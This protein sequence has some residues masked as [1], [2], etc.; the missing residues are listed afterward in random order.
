[1]QRDLK[2]GVNQ[3]TLY[4]PEFLD[5]DGDGFRPYDG[6]C[7]DA[8]PT[9][10]PD[11]EEECDGIDNDCDDEIDEGVEGI[12]YED[13]D[14]DG[15]G[16]P[17]SS[18]ST[19][20]ETPDY[21]YDSSDCDDG[22]G[23][24]HPDASEW[25]N[26]L[27][28]DCNGLIDEVL[29]VTVFVW[30]SDLDGDGFGSDDSSVETAECFPPD[31]F[32]SEGRDCQDDDPYVFPGASETCD[33]VDN[34]C[35]DYVD[36]G[37]TLT[38][39]VDGDADGHGDPASAMEV[40]DPPLGAVD[41]D[42]DCDDTDAVIYEGAPEYCDDKDNDCDGDTD[43][44]EDIVDAPTWYEDSDGDGYG[45]SESAWTG[46]DPPTGY[47]AMGGDPDDAD[48]T[49]IGIDSDE[50][51]IPDFIEGSVDT[52]GDGTSDMD[53]IDSD[54][55]GITDII[56]AG[57]EDGSTP[58]VDTDVD[59]VPDYLD[60]DSDG[61]GLSDAEEAGGAPPVDTDGDLVPDYIDTDSDG[62][63]L[64]DI[65]E[66]EYGTDPTLV[67]TD[68]D[69]V[70][71]TAEL[72]G[73]SDPT[74]GGT[75]TIIL[76]EGEA[77]TLDL[78]VRIPTSVDVAFLL[79]T[80]GSMGSTATAMA[81][82][83]TAI[84]DEISAVAD[85]VQ[86][87]FATYDDYA[88]GGFGYVSSGDKPFILRHQ[89]SKNTDSVNS[90]LASVPLHYGGDAPESGMEG[91]YQGLAG[92]GYD[93]NCDGSY[94]SD[95]D[96]LPFVAG[97]FDPFEGLGGD[98]FDSTISGGG[99]IGGFGFRAGTV[100]VVI[101]ATDNFLR[102]PDAGY[103]T[104][105]GCLLD[106]GASDV[107]AAALS[108]NAKLVGVMASST[109]ASPQMEALALATDSIADTD[110]DGVADDTLVFTWTG[111]SESFRAIVVNAITSILPE[112]TVFASVAMDVED[113]D[114][115]FVTSISP[116]E[117]TSVD[118]SDGETLDFT[119]ALEGVVAAEDGDQWFTINL[120]IV[121]DGSSV[122]AS[123]SV[124][125]LVPGDWTSESLDY[126][127]TPISPGTFDMGCTPEMDV[128]VGCNL[129][130]LPVHEVE[131]TTE[132]S[133]GVTEVTQAQWS[134]VMGDNPSTFA[135]CGD[136]CPVEMV[137]WYDAIEY[138]NALSDLDGLS[139]AYT[140]ETD[141][142]V[143]WDTSSDGYRLPTEA[144]WEYAARAGEATTYAGS[145]TIDDVSW[146]ADS[147]GA[148]T[149]PV[150]SLLPNA[151]GLMDM[152]GNVSEWVWDTYDS[153]YYAS[154]PVSDPMGG[155]DGINQAHRGGAWSYDLRQHR[156]SYRNA[157]MPDSTYSVIGLRL[158]R[159]ILP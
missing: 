114:E 41:N 88:Y 60:S 148:T 116:A 95:T 108:L 81:S 65:E 135:S 149:H 19:C 64:L 57:D 106:A 66:A 10:F 98:S 132:F 131:L 82:E 9:R 104:P 152:S 5:L 158:A 34:D 150:G 2:V 52:D 51:T 17:D 147:S 61:D 37:V 50:D 111:G 144:E 14:G 74:S 153:Y 141:D 18:I 105:G 30:Y 80:T 67:D 76:N 113:D 109:T 138:A 127:M 24:I 6:D 3:R 53:D 124:Q 118:L 100:P 40:C 45:T 137:S 92:A 103:P 97:P 145:D 1:M 75:A 102:D 96:V 36:E 72:E 157:N 130:E 77:L 123:R 27:D 112:F 63:G 134:S 89:I 16:N 73:G 4:P 119:L 43:E 94:N 38:F 69:W 55:D 54:G 26:D 13:A 128:G 8:D 133:I 12:M 31:G 79:D 86:Y 110:L 101:Y 32:V 56:E 29:E 99:T 84:V 48:S 28:D 15:Y 22:N 11:N 90:A 122:L 83:F 151:H 47:S 44:D 68:G 117:Y 129:D 136:S 126:P 139:R 121:G 159:T 125:I 143:T 93:Q 146:Y 154:S 155:D 71:D 35:D 120:Q 58:P 42:T 78:S 156:V 20:D 59:G 7:D 23:A 87:G 85:D 70:S 49:V 25:C 140:V 142:T 21:V 46:C 39:W 91:L 115:G 107:I 33:G 62:D